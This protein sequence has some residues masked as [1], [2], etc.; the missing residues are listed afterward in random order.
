[1]PVIGSD[2]ETT[3]GAKRV[4]ETLLDLWRSLCSDY[5]KLV[6]PV[7]DIEVREWMEGGVHTQLR[8][9]QSCEQK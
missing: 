1:V 2:L 9:K 8:L 3:S 4:R 7:F 6:S 5:N